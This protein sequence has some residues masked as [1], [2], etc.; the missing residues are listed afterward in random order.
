MNLA[1]Q[2]L[3]KGDGLGV[4]SFESTL[5]SRILL[6]PPTSP[7]VLRMNMCN[8]TKTLTSP[9]PS[10]PSESIVMGAKIGSHLSR[11]PS[12]SRYRWLAPPSAH[13]RILAETAKKKQEVLRW[14]L[15]RLHYNS[16]LEAKMSEEINIIEITLYGY[17]FEAISEPISVT[18]DMLKWKQIDYSRSWPGWQ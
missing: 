8:D 7:A 14:I 1:C 12:V 9:D 15:D 3:T 4:K 6:R 10:L 18:A 17:T 2:P 13:A 5:A 16:D 11:R